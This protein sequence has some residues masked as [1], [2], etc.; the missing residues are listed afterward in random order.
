MAVTINEGTQTTIKVTADA[1]GSI[2]HI[3]ADGGTVGTLT[4]VGSLTDLGTVKEVTTV[5][6]VTSVANLAK[7]TITALAKGTISV[8]TVVVTAGTIVETPAIGVR[9]ADEF[10]TVV[11]SGTTDLGT[12]KG[13]VDGSQIFITDLIV[14][15]GTATDVEIGDGG[16]SKP[17]VG[18]LHFT[19]LGGIS[20][21]NFKTYPRTSAGSPLVFKQSTDGPLTLT[22]NGYVD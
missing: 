10:A 9:H 19:N 12:I 13:S 7:G 14:S 8:G 21:P 4:N 5:A 2:Q 17:I 3:R 1:G 15:A 18:S 16:T 20:A 11:S 22:V 6:A